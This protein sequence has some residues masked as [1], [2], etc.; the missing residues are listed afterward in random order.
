M[1]M[2]RDSRRAASRAPSLMTFSRSAPVK[3]EVDWARTRRSTSSARGLPLAWT[4]RISSRPRLSGRPTYTCRSNRP[5]RSRAG[6]RISARLVAARTT[7]PSLLPK[8]SIS[9]SSW[10]RVCSRSSWPPPR[11]APRWRPTASISSMNTT[12][13]AA[14]LASSK[15]SRTRL[16]P[17]PT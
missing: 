13:G 6:S 12:E 7:T 8:P 4:A 2:N 14:F 5:G 15:R 1:A 11:P 17:T 3:P 9:T 16:A 10:L